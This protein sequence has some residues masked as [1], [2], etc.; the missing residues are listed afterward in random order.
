MASRIAALRRHL[1]SSTADSK[2]FDVGTMQVLQP[3]IVVAKRCHPPFLLAVPPYL[4]VHHPLTLHPRQRLLDGDNLEMRAELREFFRRD[5]FRPRFDIA[6]EDER[7]L[8]LRRLQAMCE[9]PGRFVSAKDFLTNPQRIFAAHELACLVD[10]S[11]A[12]KVYP[13]PPR[14]L[15]LPR[16]SCSSSW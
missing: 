6:L 7:A 1:S 2:S 15:Q 4:A 13:P 5:I 8:A 12:T 16:S 3:A 9:E 14:E 10:G 11:L